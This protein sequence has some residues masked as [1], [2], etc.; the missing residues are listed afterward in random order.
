MLAELAA[1]NLAVATVK[2][3]AQHS[4]DI[5]QIFK[6]MGEMLTAR[7]KIQK[8]VTKKGQSDLEAYAAHVE[9][10]RKYDEVVEILK[11]TGHW[12]SYLK[13][14][15]DRRKAEKEEAARSAREARAR[16]KKWRDAAL[17]ILIILATLLGVGILAGLIWLGKT[18]GR[19]L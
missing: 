10:K 4:G 11:W 13:F 5:V 16:R 8:T 18:Q 1:F 12:E 19:G 7:D 6:G 9:M 17:I 2:E 14:C 15:S 3:A